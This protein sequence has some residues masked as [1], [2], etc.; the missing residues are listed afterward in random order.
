MAKKAKLPEVP[1]YTPPEKPARA[2][3]KAAAAEADP[4]L[5][6]ITEQLRPLAVPCASLVFDPANARTHG[7]KNLDAIRGSLAVYGQRKPVVVNRRTGH[8]ESGNGT[9]QAALSLGWSHLAAVF[10]DDDQATATGFS[11][12]DNRTAELAGWDDAVLGQL[13]C[14][15]NT[16]NDPQLDAMI[17]DLARA[18]GIVPAEEKPKEPDASTHEPEPNAVIVCPSCGHQWDGRIT[19]TQEKGDDS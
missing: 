7:G 1:A 13:L 3:A 17:A 14:D 2:K 16:G 10:V 12:A 9:L 18:E 6:R 19:V 8:V 15:I 4:D 11:I 5:S